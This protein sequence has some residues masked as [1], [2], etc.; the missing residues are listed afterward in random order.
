[1]TLSIPPSTE[2]SLTYFTN[3]FV[4]LTKYLTDGYLDPDIGLVERTIRKFA[5]GRNDWLFADTPKGADASALLYSIVITAKLNGVNPYLALVEILKQI[6]KAQSVDDY[7]RLAELILSR[8]PA[9]AT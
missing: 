5:I 3:E 8:G 1:M 9:L 6:P 2:K 4:Y 7:E